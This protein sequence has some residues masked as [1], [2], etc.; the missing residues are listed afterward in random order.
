MSGR[1]ADQDQAVLRVLLL[2][3]P[4]GVEGAGGDD[5]VIPRGRVVMG[6]RQ[7]VVEPAHRQARAH[8]HHGPGLVAA[9]R[10]QQWQMGR[11]TGADRHLRRRQV[12]GPTQ[13]ST[14]TGG[15][16]LPQWWRLDLINA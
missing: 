5:N 11:M 15:Q 1:A 16:R 3:C 6:R 13:G 2:A 14:H 7:T 12:A 8:Q 9:A 10:G 4:H